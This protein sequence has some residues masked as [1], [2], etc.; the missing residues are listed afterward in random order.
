MKSNNNLTL[1]NCKQGDLSGAAEAKKGS[2]A[3]VDK[4]MIAPVPVQKEGA[5][6]V[7]AAKK[8]TGATNNYAELSRK[9]ADHRLFA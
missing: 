2:G 6:T 9:A 3:S 1:P 5:L 4:S 8:G 7:N